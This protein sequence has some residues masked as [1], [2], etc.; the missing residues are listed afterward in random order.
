MKN[1]SIYLAF[2]K[3]F[4]QDIDIINILEKLYEIEIIVKSV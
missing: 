4:T 1:Y 3:H 2:H